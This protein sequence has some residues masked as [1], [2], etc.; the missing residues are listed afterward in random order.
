MLAGNAKKNT[1][2]HSV[3]GSWTPALAG[4]SSAETH[5]IEQR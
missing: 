5:E 4:S 2:P 1:V 3:S